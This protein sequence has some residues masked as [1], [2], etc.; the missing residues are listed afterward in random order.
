MAQ[1][2]GGKFARRVPGK[3]ERFS[4]RRAEKRVAE[5]VEHERQCAFGNVMIL[6]ADRQLG[7]EIAD[8]I[9][10]GVEGVTVAREDH[11][12]R[13]CPG[14]FAAECIETL[15]HDHTRVGFARAGALDGLGNARGDGIG[16]RLGEFALQARSRAEMVKE[17]GV[18]SPDPGSNGLERY[19]GGS[20][21]QEEVPRGIERGRTALPRA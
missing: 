15:I 6:M 16:D 14:A 19:C 4:D 17:V 13:Q 12:G 3:A 21:G 1:P 20:F 2:L 8:R 18:R 7:D 10:D 9:E 11:P 5:C